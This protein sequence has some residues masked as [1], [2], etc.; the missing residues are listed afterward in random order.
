MRRTSVIAA[1]ISVGLAVSLSGCFANPLDQLTEGLVEGLVEGGVEQ[2]IE[3]GS[4]VDIDFGDGAAL[5][6]DWPAALPVP[7]GEILLSGSSEGTSTIAMNT[8]VAFAESGLADL[9]NSGFTIAQE[10]S[11]G[12]GAKVY[13][14]ENDSYTVSYA[15][16]DS[17]DEGVVFLQYGVTPKS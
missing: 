16:A 7:D 6:S 13:I 11:I 5:P 3:Q 2:L 1:T 17:S 12:D 14:L 4:G 10:Q 9:V 15:W 8:T